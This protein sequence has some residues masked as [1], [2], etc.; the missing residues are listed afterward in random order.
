MPE[1]RGGF[2]IKDADDLVSGK[3]KVINGFFSRRELI[4]FRFFPI[5]S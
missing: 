4:A 1:G 2:F 3:V 5:D